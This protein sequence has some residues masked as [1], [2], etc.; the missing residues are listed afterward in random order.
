M[1]KICGKEPLPLELVGEHAGKPFLDEDY[2]GLHPLLASFYEGEISAYPNSFGLFFCDCSREPAAPRTS[3]T[4][5][6]S[7]RTVRLCAQQLQSQHVWRHDPMSW[8]W[9]G[10]NSGK[11]EDRV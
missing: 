10:R 11:M 8:K 5:A 7:W 3:T 4:D 1:C 9:G 6:S 2:A